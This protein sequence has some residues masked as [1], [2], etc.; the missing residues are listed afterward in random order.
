VQ[1]IEKLVGHDSLDI[2]FAVTG[3]GRVHILQVRPIAV[4]HLPEPID[5]EQVAVTL[6]DA[7][8]FLTARRPPG[9]TLVGSTTRYSVMADWNPA[10]IIG[11]KPKRLALSLYRYL[12]TDDVWAQQR[13]EYGYRDVRPCPLI[14]E[15]G[16][17]PYVDVR[18][19]FNSFVPAE[20]PDDLAHRLVDHYL[21]HLAR[22]PHLHDKVE[23]EV[24]FTCLTVDFDERA[25]R[26]RAAGFNASEIAALRAALLTITNRGFERL[27]FDLGQLPVLEARL[28]RIDAADLA[29]LDR[30]F[31]LLE[32]T[33]RIGTLAFAHLARAGFVAS[34]LL[35][36]LHNVGA[37]TAQEVNA[38][39]GS[40]ETVLG[41]MQTD[42]RRV[43]DGELSWDAF[44]A[45]YGHLRPGTYDITSPCYRSAAEQY[46][47]PV[48]ERASSTSGG[49]SAAASDGVWSI[50]TRRAVGE[51][52]A[53]AGLPVDAERFE[54][55]A[56]GAIAG[57]EEGKFVFTKGLSAALECLAAFGETQGLSR[58][59]LAHV[60]IADLLACREVVTQPG[61]FLDRRVLEGREAFH[62]AQGVCLPGQ[63]GSE[64][65][66]FCFEQ[67]AAEPNFV[68]LGAVEAPVVAYDL[69]PASDVD[70]KIVLIPNADPGFDWLLARDIAGLVTM[71]GGANSHMAVRA[72]E[73]GLP[74]AIGVG[75]LLYAALEPAA[76]IRL[77]CASRT[78]S[79]VQ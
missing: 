65:D 29:P 55:F 9:P 8:R 3:D 38:F 66:L 57:R 59:E 49:A 51:A 22:H 77:D 69:S 58:E 68:S 5:D 70:G 76:V 40:V 56:R 41:R 43:R 19:T 42:G 2:E 25:E 67:E 39:L 35:R 46:L 34:A 32:Q 10:E 4:T 11:T 24:L 75:E 78:I 15:I 53:A 79:V 52:L 60:P 30:A 61:A 1:N 37:L 16:G 23:F 63:I 62:I 28:A 18:A 14:V 7:R 71:Y 20:L 54:Q 27:A 44:V 74:A 73:L 6:A 36:S 12:I 50:Q 21:D 72:A 47:R 45:S 26:L 31:H 17:H 64:I 33:R 13:A 48:V